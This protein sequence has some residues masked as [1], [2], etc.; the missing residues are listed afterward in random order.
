MC[1]KI[2]WTL[3][4]VILQLGLGQACWSGVD[5]VVFVVKEVVR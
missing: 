5:I 2:S 1:W 3:A 4:N